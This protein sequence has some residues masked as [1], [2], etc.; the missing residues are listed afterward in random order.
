MLSVGPL[1]QVIAIQVNYEFL[2]KFKKY[3][4][5][6]N[7]KQYFSTS[8]FM[9]FENKCSE[10]ISNFL[11]FRII[12]NDQLSSGLESHLRIYQ[13]KHGKQYQHL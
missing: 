10:N 13:A 11:Y 4:N 9:V 2:T 6:G 12:Q 3:N 1:D 8:R 5:I 7:F